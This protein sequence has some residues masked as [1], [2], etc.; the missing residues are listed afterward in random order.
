MATVSSVIGR[1]PRTPAYPPARG[2]D[3]AARLSL[4]AE[5]AGPLL[6]AGGVEAGLEPV[7]GRLLGRVAP[8][9][10]LLARRRHDHLPVGHLREV[11]AVDRRRPLQVHLYHRPVIR[12]Q[13]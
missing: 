4:G 3:T 1:V 2:G 8:R 11:A 9:L 6:P 13:A 5:A 7:V 12:E 10:R